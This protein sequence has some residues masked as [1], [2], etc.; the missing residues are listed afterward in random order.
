MIIEERVDYSLEEEVALA[1]AGGADLED[2]LDI[3]RSRGAV[4][5]DPEDGYGRDIVPVGKGRYPGSSRM[6]FNIWDE[7]TKRGVPAEDLA[8]WALMKRSAAIAEGD[9]VREHAEALMAKV[10]AYRD[11]ALKGAD[12]EIAFFERVLDQYA[13]D[14]G[15]PPDTP[16][17]MAFVNGTLQR[18]KQRERIEWEDEAALNWAATRADVD[19]LAPRK[20]NRSATKAALI[21]R[22]MSFADGKTGELVGF[23]KI[24]APDAPT[25]FSIKQ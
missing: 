16:G 4:E 17:K 21:H 15:L 19:T 13:E 12:Q 11:K 5:A 23:V 20:L 9:H 3:I 2:V 25:A 6:Y 7:A 8:E 18:T 1:L 22:G 24:V 10:V 14:A